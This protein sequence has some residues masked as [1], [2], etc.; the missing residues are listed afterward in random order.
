MKVSE[1]KVGMLLKFKKPIGFKF[2]RDHKDFYWL[3]PLPQSTVV[4]D[5]LMIYLGQK[6]IPEKTHYGMPAPQ[7][8]GYK[9]VRE[10]SVNGMVAWVWPDHWR[11]LEPAERKDNG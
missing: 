7:R 4:Q 11:L 2:L 9:N 6:E 3:D 10:V 5:P 1:L 8:D